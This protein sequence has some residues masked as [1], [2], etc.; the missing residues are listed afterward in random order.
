MKKV[1]FILGP[2]AVGKTYFSVKLAQKFNGEIISSDS[3]Q[4]YRGL[5]IGSAK[6]TKDEMQGIPHHA[7][8]IL[9][10]EE[11]FSVYEF[12][13]Y[14]RKKIDEIIAR[15]KLPIVVGGT[16]LYVKAL[17]GGYNFGG[18]E[19]D[20]KLRQELEKLAKE[21]GNDYLFEMLKQKDEKLAEKTDKNNLVRLIRAIE[22]ASSNGEKTQNK[23]DIDA[24]VVALNRERSLLYAD[25]NKRVD[26]MLQNGLIEEVEGLKKRGLT[27]QNQSMRAI[28]YKE[29]LAYLDGE[30]S[31]EQMVEILKQHSRNYAKRQLTFLRGM[32]NVHFVDTEDR[33]KAFDTLSKLI[34]NWR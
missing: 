8:D 11:E 4:I 14:T 25:I 13:E 7:I 5:D 26:I 28:D 23:V 6:V 17:L 1:L 24:L 15:N 30:C 3:V 20:E 10:P 29:V 19:K 12:V 32:E 33:A 22:I 31:Y 27:A 34:E 21:K 18:T 9:E 2:T 16:G